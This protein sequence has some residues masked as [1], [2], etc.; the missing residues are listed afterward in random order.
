MMDKRGSG[1]MEEARSNWFRA[2][3]YVVGK[4]GLNNLRF[5][6]V[7]GFWRDAPT[8]ESFQYNMTT[9]AQ[10]ENLTMVRN[11]IKDRI[12]PMIHPECGPPLIPRQL[13]VDIRGPGRIDSQYIIRQKGEQLPNRDREEDWSRPFAS[14][15][16]SWQSLNGNEM[17]GEWVDEPQD[18]EWIEEAWVRDGHDMCRKPIQR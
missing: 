12:W 4:G 2:L 13:L 11:F 5:L 16:I 3:R 7:T 1:A 15:A 9:A 18:G 10:G 14:R 6:R 17:A 8:Q